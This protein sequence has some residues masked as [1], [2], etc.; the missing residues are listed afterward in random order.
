MHPSD[1]PLALTFDDVNLVP[2]HSSVPSRKSPTIRSIV[3]DE[4]L[5]IPIIA[6]PMNTICEIEMARTMRDIGADAVIHRYMTIGQQKK[7]FVKN[8]WM[9]IGASGDYLQRAI[10]LYQLGVRKFCIDVAN[11]H[12]QICIDAIKQITVWLKR[13]FDYPLY[14]IM[15]GNVCTYKGAV[16]FAEIGVDA[17]RVGIGS[18]GACSTRLVTGY[19]VPQLTALES[20]LEIKSSFPNV[21]IISD[22]GIRGSG[23]LIKCFALGC[24]AVMIGSLLSASS[25]TPGEVFEDSDGYQFKRF[26]GM[27]S[28]E[29]RISWYE[30][31]QTN[32]VPEGESFE[33]EYKGDTKKIVLDLAHSLK[34][35]MSYG[36]AMNL[37]QFKQNAKWVQ[38]TDNGRKEGYPN[39]KLNS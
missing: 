30:R 2:V 11:G 12:S 28:K 25:D 7:H 38:V 36:G 14:K 15:A 32:F 21:S 26:S 6:S 1:V 37:K 10:Q 13:N 23:D 17:I 27:A 24:D 35:G 8:C 5:K 29:A 4:R 3:A 34:V 39:K 9:A 22:G 31:E 20:C 18:G 19:G 16:D 33:V